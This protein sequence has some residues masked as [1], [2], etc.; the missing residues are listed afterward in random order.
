M[1]RFE[2]PDVRGET[3]DVVQTPDLGTMQSQIDAAASAAAA[4]Q[5]AIPQPATSAP[6]PVAVDSVA[7]AATPYARA[8]HTH[9]SRLQARR[10]QITPNASGQYDYTFPLPYDGG[11]VPIVNVTC[12]TPTGQSFRYDAGILQGSTTNQKTTIVVTK[13]N[14]SVVTGLL[15]A[16]LAVFVPATTALWVNIMSRAPS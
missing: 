1:P 4:A 13:T 12:E 15:N 16:V 14:A 2:I 6:P 8:D 7:G 9:Q 11:V 10:I 3:R 5:A